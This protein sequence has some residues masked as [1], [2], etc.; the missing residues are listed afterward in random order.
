MHEV[1]TGP[2]ESRAQRQLS[3]SLC[4]VEPAFFLKTVDEISSGL[5]SVPTFPEAKSVCLPP[6]SDKEWVFGNGS[7]FYPTLSLG[8]QMHDGPAGDVSVSVAD[9]RLF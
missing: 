2:K 5:S 1:R 9:W 3:V 6:P 7:A 8:L 4:C